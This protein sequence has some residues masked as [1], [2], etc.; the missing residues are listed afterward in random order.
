MAVTSTSTSPR[1]GSQRIDYAMALPHPTKLLILGAVLLGLFLAALD[2]T[3]VATALP[4]I[5]RDFNGID[6]ISWV[7][8][9]YLLAS[10][11]M[12]PIYGKLSD[13]Y[14]RKPILLWGIVV[15]LLGSA[16]CGI[17]GSML[18]LIAF[19]VVQGI[20]AAAITSTAFA[21]P[22]DLFVPAER[23]KYMGLFGG[24]FGIASVVDHS[25][26]AC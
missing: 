2:Q 7:S 17:A 13:M 11:A 15:F 5:V 12:V 9:G 1:F 14:G 10:T 20:G 26:A 24:V 18:Q 4:A 25:W 6:L 21:T 22:A 16:L 3:I 23:P 8:A 19:R